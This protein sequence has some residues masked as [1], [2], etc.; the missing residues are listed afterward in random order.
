MKF[1]SVTASLFCLT[2]KVTACLAIL[3]T[4]APASAGVM[5]AGVPDETHARLE[6]WLDAG[7][8]PGDTTSVSSWP[9]SSAYSRNATQGTV[10]SQP[11]YTASNP[12]FANRPTVHFDGGDLLIS[13][14]PSTMKR[15]PSTNRIRRIQPRCFGQQERRWIRCKCNRPII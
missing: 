2:P 14:T 7:A 11:T 5:N 3:L 10:S 15:C 8:L 6:L 9:D 1:P 4:T 12:L 13:A